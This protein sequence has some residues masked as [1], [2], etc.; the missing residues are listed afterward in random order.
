[1]RKVANIDS[2]VCWIIFRGLLIC[3]LLTSIC[4]IQKKQE[5][6]ISTQNFLA[7]VVHGITFSWCRHFGPQL[8]KTKKERGE[9]EVV[10]ERGAEIKA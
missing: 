4:E 1:M 5:K 7:S 3:I 6:A 8:V 9:T 2:S 10:R